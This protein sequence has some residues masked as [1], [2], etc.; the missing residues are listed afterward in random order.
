MEQLA[1]EGQSKALLPRRTALLTQVV[2]SLQIRQELK[3]L[4]A[5]PRDLTAPLT[6]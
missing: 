2:Y 1:F 4:I 3:S 6:G 5:N